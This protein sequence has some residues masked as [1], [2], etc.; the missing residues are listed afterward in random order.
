MADEITKPTIE[1]AIAAIDL[2]A[3]KLLE[4][5]GNLQAKTQMEDDQFASVISATITTAVEGGIKLYDL[6]GLYPLKLQESNARKDLV[7][8]QR[9]ALDDARLVKRAELVLNNVGLIETGG[10]SAPAA[11]WTAAKNSINAI[12]PDEANPIYP[13]DEPIP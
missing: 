4:R 10:T 6:D 2:I 8:R 7:V 13:D 12:I 9:D 3:D 11:A 1:Q 5:I